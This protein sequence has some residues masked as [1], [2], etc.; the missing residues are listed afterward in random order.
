M[1]TYILIGLAFII[2]ESL[3]RRV[4]GGWLAEIPYKDSNIKDYLSEKYHISIRTISQILNIGII[5]VILKYVLDATW[6]TS[7][8]IPCIV[9]LLFWLPGHGPF[10]DIGRDKAPSMDIIHRYNKE[11]Y[12][13]ILYWCFKHEYWYG[14]FFDYCGMLLRYGLPTLLLIPFYG[15]SILIL[16]FAIASVYGIC[17]VCSDNGKIKHPT[18]LAEFIVGAIVGAFLYFDPLF[19]YCF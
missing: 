18:N 15:I 19:L 1:V 3:F 14:E 5:F 11:W 7:I 12:T 8:I 10:F 6:I 4:F 9:Q 2:F 16:P 13:K 17:W